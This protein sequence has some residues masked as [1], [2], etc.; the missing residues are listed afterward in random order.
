MTM[1]SAVSGATANFEI[2]K[3]GIVIGETLSGYD[4][5]LSGNPMLIQVPRQEGS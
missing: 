4:G 2:T 1:I 3:D 5:L